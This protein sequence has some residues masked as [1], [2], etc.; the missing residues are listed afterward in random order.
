MKEWLKELFDAIDRK[1]V[2]G[3]VSFFAEDACFR[4]ANASSV[5]KKKNIHRAV[6]SFFSQ[7]KGLK[8]HILEVW[9]DDNIVICEG[10]VTYLR[11]DACRIT[12][13]FV[14]ILRR[15][16]GLINDYRIYMDIS[17]LFA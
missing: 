15:E 3:F 7:I 9:G 6:S 8:H 13:P 10:E 11:E 1:D 5:S 4:F 16:G 2:D 12:L 17:P 14:N